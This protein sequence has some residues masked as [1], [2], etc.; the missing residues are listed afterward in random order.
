MLIEMSPVQK[1]KTSQVFHMES[2]KAEVTEKK[3]KSSKGGGG[4]EDAETLPQGHT[5]LAR[6][7]AQELYWMAQ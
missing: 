2:R 7:H 4:G 1:E 3:W 5:I 6:W